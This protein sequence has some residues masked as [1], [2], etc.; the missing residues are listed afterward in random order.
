[1][2]IHTQNVK[3]ASENNIILTT[4]ILITNNP[5]IILNE[6]ELNKSSYKVIKS[7]LINVPY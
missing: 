6:F 7:I 1:M 3:L 5:Q 4:T 2:Y